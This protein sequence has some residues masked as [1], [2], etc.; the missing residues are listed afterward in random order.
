MG[1][2]RVFDQNN[3]ATTHPELAGQWHPTKN[4]DLTPCG[5]SFGSVHKIWWLCEEGHSWEATVNHRSSGTGCA[6]CRGLKVEVGFNDLATLRPDLAA[7]WHPTKNGDLTPQ[8]ITVNSNKKIWWLC[9]KG[10]S[11]SVSPNIRFAGNGCAT[12]SGQKVEVGFND[13][14]TLRP[15][16]AAE[17]HPTKNVDLTPQDITVGSGRK[18]WW[19]C[20]L[21]HSWP[22][23]P[24]TRLRGSGCAACASTGFDPAKP[25]LLYFLSNSDYQS[26]KVGITNVGS[27]RLA[28]FGRTGWSLM[29]FVEHR[30]GHVV[31]TVEKAVF[32]WLRHELAMPA[33]LGPEEMRRTRGWTETFSMEGPSDADVTARI[34]SEFAK[35]EQG[36]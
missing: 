28:E 10:H 14:A 3:L 35:L 21:G 17:W 36:V 4:G 8:D 12:C 9:E 34:H 30:D 1:V 5:V 16:L 18:V 13:L 29:T 22:A 24:A 32:R 15:D 20:N 11:W 25:A 23:A 33:F 7:E 31:A 2:R 19:S 26:R 27:T 6:V